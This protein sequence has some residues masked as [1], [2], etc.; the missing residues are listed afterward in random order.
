MFGLNVRKVTDSAAGY[1]IDSDI[2]F[3][4]SWLY[5]VDER[6][7]IGALAQD[8]NGPKITVAGLG[9]VNRVRNY[10]V[11]MAFRPTN[12]TV[13]TIDGYD[14]ANNGDAQSARFGIE[15]RLGSL[16][17]R[18]GY[19]G[20]GSNMDQGATFGVGWKKDSYTL[21]ATVLSGDFDNTILISGSFEVL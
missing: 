11:G 21:D 5:R 10:R 4:A 19:Y 3:D 6:L 8:F 2:G 12:D 17:F 13:V 20:V 15:K 18:A 16:A 1:S 14:L 7:T 9:F